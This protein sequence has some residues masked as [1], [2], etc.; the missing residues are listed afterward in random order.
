MPHYK[1]LLQHGQWF[2]VNGGLNLT[3]KRLGEFTHAILSVGGNFG[4]GWFVMNTNYNRSFVGVAV[5]LTPDMK[6]QVEETLPWLVLI[7]PPK[8]HLN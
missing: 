6:R 7:D 5:H 3:K 4:D 2:H 8:V 1:S